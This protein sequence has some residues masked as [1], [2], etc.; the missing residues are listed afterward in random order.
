MAKRF[1]VQDR[2]QIATKYEIWQAVV[3][4]QRWWRGKRGKHETF[5]PDTIK[6]CHRKLMTTGSVCDAERSGRSPTS[7]SPV[8][9]DV[10][11]EMFSRSP[12][13]SIMKASLESSLT[14]YTIHS[15][16]TKKLHYRAWKPHLVQEIFPE[17]CDI[18]LE[19][20]EIMLVWKKD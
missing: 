5:H 16:L 2:A 3:A 20:S 6:N 10:V 7:R 19:F 17:D 8:V 1:S 11:Q 12:E 9:V 13:T 14:R 4:V 18:R 15:V